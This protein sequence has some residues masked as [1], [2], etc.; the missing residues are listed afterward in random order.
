MNRAG[1][2]MNTRWQGEP[3]YG[4]RRARDSEGTRWRAVIT[5]STVFIT[6]LGRFASTGGRIVEFCRT[7]GRAPDNLV[8]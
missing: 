1:V 5:P 8:W 7:T 3:F 4:L 2:V 6:L